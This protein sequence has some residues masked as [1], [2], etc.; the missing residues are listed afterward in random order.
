MTTTLTHPTT[1]SD[2]G[3]P[4]ASHPR[5]TSTDLLERARTLA[6]ALR[7]RAAEG[8]RLRRLP[9]DLAGQIRDAGLFQMLMPESLGGV[10]CDLVTVVEVIELLSHADGSAGWTTMIGNSSAFFAWLDPD[11]AA[12]M[13]RAT[14]HPVSTSMFGPHGRAVDNGD[15]TLTVDG[16]WPYNS[17]VTHADWCQVGIMVM[18]GD[19]PRLRPDGRPD[20]RFA[21]V[22][23]SQVG[24][25]DTWDSL[26][27]RGTGSHDVEIT[28][29][30][31]PEV[32]TAMP[33]FDLPRHDG[34]H[35]RLTFWTLISSLMAGFPLGIGRRALDEFTSLA[36]TKRRGPSPT[37]VAED[38]HVQIEL[39]R[40][41]GGLQAARSFALDAVGDCWETV[42][43]GGTPT[44]AQDARVLLCIQQAMSAALDATQL[45]FRMSGSGAADVSMPVQRCFRDLSTA[46]LHLAFSDERLA[47]VGRMQLG[48]G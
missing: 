28:G 22:P 34:P 31:V 33:M 27:L 40:V 21:F 29:L 25:I 11:A 10:A 8:D 39:G 35:W 43:A 47:E 12:A 48:L 41:E 1:T 2:Q 42:L 15:G 45:A 38:R 19:H 3:G 5:P 6:P 18:D 9:D 13:L 4:I 30:V 14:P 44:A 32:H 26:G 23:R 46:D 16:R 17:G 24:V 7:D 36:M 37:T 20:W